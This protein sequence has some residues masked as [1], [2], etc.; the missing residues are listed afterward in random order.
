M[1]ALRYLRGKFPD[2]TA[3]QFRF[4]RRHGFYPDRAREY[5]FERY[6]P[7]D[8]F[9]DSSAGSPGR[10]IEP[11]DWECCRDKLFFALLMGAI[12]ASTPPVLAENV[13]G[14]IIIYTDEA[15]DFETLL[16]ARGE[17]VVKP[18]GNVGGGVGVRIVRPDDAD[19]APRPGELVTPR[20]QQHA[21]AA[22]IYP[23]SANTIRAMTAWDYDAG[24]VFVG[25]AAHRFGSSLAATVDNWAS[26][27]LAA[28]IDLATGRLGPAI[29][30]PSV[31]P[32]RVRHATHPD[33][34][35]QIEGVEIPRFGEMCE[36][37]LAVARRFP[38]RYVGW[39]IVITPDAWTLVEANHIAELSIFQCHRPVLLDPRLRRFYERE[40]V[41]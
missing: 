23:G 38:R 7:E 24:D 10:T 16:R 22:T 34:K 18:R 31:D 33:T 37:L 13:N 40:G 14:R 4:C 1:L 19:P 30:L 35:A 28:G 6:R 27:G 5:D 11:G 12:G 21:Y 20:I 29:R 25:A 15:A 36:G 2:I 8:Y 17:L 9:P 3:E 26:G 32:Q 39:D 41:L